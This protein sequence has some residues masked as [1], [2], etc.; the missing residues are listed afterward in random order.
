MC[1]NMRRNVGR[2][3][4]PVLLVMVLVAATNTGN[5]STY[6]ADSLLLD[7]LGNMGVM[8]L[9]NDP[10]GLPTAVLVAQRAAAAAARNAWVRRQAA[11]AYRWLRNGMSGYT[12]GWLIEG[13]FG[14]HPGGSVGLDGLD[15]SV[16]DFE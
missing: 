8:E 1:Q 2:A 14:Y 9:R 5:N 10:T 6:A 13:I 4:V 12:F 15:E 11:R 3:T 7:E 16:F